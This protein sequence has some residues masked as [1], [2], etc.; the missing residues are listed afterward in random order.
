MTATK[1]VVREL[2]QDL[3]SI[4][5]PVLD[6]VL[7][8]VLNQNPN[9]VPDRDPI[10]DRSQ[11]LDRNQ[12][13]SLL[14]D[15]DQDRDQILVQNHHRDLDQDR[16]LHRNRPRALDQHL[17]Q[18]QPQ[19]HHQGQGVSRVIDRDPDHAPIPRVPPGLGQLLVPV[20]NL[21]PLRNTQIPNNFYYLLLYYFN[22]QINT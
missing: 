18:G 12:N 17:N 20:P 9:H 6:L 10:P 4:P 15:H 5:N 16:S 19:N 8:R 22:F 14:P 11:D 1:R 2:H 7:H 13:P 3:R 21:G